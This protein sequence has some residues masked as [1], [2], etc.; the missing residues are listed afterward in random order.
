MAQRFKPIPLTTLLAGGF[1]LDQLLA[2]P[3][4]TFYSALVRHAQEA[5]SI[6]IAGYGFGDLHVNRAIRNRFERTYD[7]RSSPSVVILE[8]SRPERARTGRLEINQFWSYELTHTLRTT[9]SDG[10]E[11]PSKNS[12]TIEDFIVEREFEQ[13]CKT[14]VAIWHGG[15]RE[16]VSD[17]DKIVEWLSKRL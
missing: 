11:N 13:D 9:F 10:C 1:K 16:A 17:V 12:S 5:D 6:L 8:K 15:F 3:Y 14:R 7:D 4:Q 2:D